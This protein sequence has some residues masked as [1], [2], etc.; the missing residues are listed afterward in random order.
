MTDFL[1]ERTSV[2]AK[3]D[4]C[5]TIRNNGHIYRGRLFFLDKYSVCNSDVEV[6]IKL[7]DT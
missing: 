1:L 5:Y 4:N 3:A 7:R 2:V 6:F